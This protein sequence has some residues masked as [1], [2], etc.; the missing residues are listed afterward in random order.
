MR[1][2][3]FVVDTFHEYKLSISPFGMRLVLKWSAEFL[4]GHISIKYSIIRSTTSR[5]KMI[6]DVSYSTYDHNVNIVIENKH[7]AV[8]RHH[9]TAE[10]VLLKSLSSQ[11]KK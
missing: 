8:K 11:R 4:N 5:I 6:R 9:T 7:H 3:I 10:Q 1:T 2:Y